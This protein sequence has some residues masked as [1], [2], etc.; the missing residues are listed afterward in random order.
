MPTL[1]RLLVASLSF[2]ASAV[3]IRSQETAPA[4]PTPATESLPSVVLITVE[5]LRD[6]DV[7]CY[8]CARDTT[9]HLDAFA[10][11]AMVFERAY[12]PAPWA[13]PALGALLT[14]R[15]PWEL[16]IVDLR[17][18]MPPSVPTLAEA[19]ADTHSTM[20][21][22]AHPFT[23]SKWGFARGFEQFD[24]KYA[25]IALER[26]T[27]KGLVDQSLRFVGRAE[28]PYFLW[29]QFLDTYPTFLEQAGHAR[30]RDPDYDGRVEAG[31]DWSTLRGGAR[32]LGDAD[33]AELQRLY[34][35]E[36]RRVDEQL[37]RLFAAMR[38]GGWYDHSLIVVTSS[39]GLEFLE[40]GGVGFGHH[41]GEELIRVPLLV[42]TPNASAGTR[43]DSPVGLVDVFPTV[44]AW[45]ERD[46]PGSIGGSVLSDSTEGGVSN[47]ALLA[48][49]AKGAD[50]RAVI[51]GSWKYVDDEAR[52]GRS[53]FDL[54]VDP[55]GLADVSA[56]QPQQVDRLRAVLDAASGNGAPV[57]AG[58]P[59]EFTDREVAFA[60]L[61]D[62]N[63]DGV[64][65]GTGIADLDEGMRRF[66]DAWNENDLGE[67]RKLFPPEPR[68]PQ[69]G[70]FERELEH[71]GW[72]E[73]LPRIREI[74]RSR[75]R[76]DS[77]VYSVH[78]GGRSLELRWVS[79]PGGWTIAG[80]RLDEN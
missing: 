75:R 3:A 72:E 52:R 59:V 58:A 14:G 68:R 16:G 18:P 38:E 46:L 57:E 1:S 40:R 70:R 45:S 10:Q 61:L 33:R 32:R 64:V 71:L 50:S 21:V 79:K 5:G 20:A 6:A 36:V 25:R 34:D 74:T 67:L 65:V 31:M 27:S 69:W 63:L 48:G 24:E 29:L 13:N 78:V 47:R 37:G 11:E 7:G 9:P 42:K 22:V 19:L 62:E 43:N 41:L 51:V 28:A 54:A 35:S 60:E 49:S 39:H 8:G 73:A 77:A 26:E 76:P 30:E 4:P 15:L 44:L 55:G 66:L 53:L 12:S 23:G 80:L 56:A 2:F 17:S